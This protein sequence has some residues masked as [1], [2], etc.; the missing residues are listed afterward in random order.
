VR[1]HVSLVRHLDRLLTEG[2]D[3]FHEEKDAVLPAARE[4]SSYSQADDTGVRHLGK[5]GYWIHYLSPTRLR[6]QVAC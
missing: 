5:N 4:V 2:H 3:R 6:A 1:S